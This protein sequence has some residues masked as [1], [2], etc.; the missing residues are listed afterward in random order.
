M[1]DL[2]DYLSKAVEDHASDIFIVAGGPVCVKLDKSVCPVDQD[3]ILPDDSEKLITSIYEHAGRSMDHFLKHG[4]DDFSFSV[5]GL[6]RFRVNTYRQRGSMAAVVRVVAFGI[7]NW[8]EL[9]IP[10][11][12]MELSTAT[13]GMILVT[14]TA[15]S[16]K[17]TTQACIIDRINQ[18]R[19]C[20]IITMENPIEYLHRNNRS[21]VSQREIAIDTE[22]YI[23]ALRA[24]LRQAP[25]VILLGEMRDHDTIRTAMTAAETGHLIIATLHTK[26]TVNTIDRI[27]DSFPSEQ[28][29]Q[30][31]TQLSMVL[32]TV[33]SQQ[34]LPGQDGNL[35][36]A[37]EIMHMNNAIKSL[38]RDNKSHQINNAIA[39]GGAEGMISMDQAILSL[40]Q[41]GK[42]SKDIALVYADNQEQ[43]QRRL[44]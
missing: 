37:F 28:Q 11:Q 24:C 22:D 5:A 40:Y 9:G 21:I 17:S 43:M 42:I 31:R 35:T 38:I 19:D 4:D 32:R 29:G 36:P 41:E 3:R 39:A 30:V 15:G 8:Q 20:H 6:A 25:D 26:G 1:R 44:V 13:H 27:V 18:T 23:S 14:G 7:P 34:L 2:L 33:V 10:E 16:G 12:V